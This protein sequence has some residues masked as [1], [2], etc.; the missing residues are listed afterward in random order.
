VPLFGTTTK[1]GF[2]LSEKTPASSEE[3]GSAKFTIENSTG[4]NGKGTGANGLDELTGSTTTGQK[5]EVKITAPWSWDAIFSGRTLTDAQVE[6]K[7][8]DTS[9]TQAGVKVNAGD[10]VQFGAEGKTT[11]KQET[12]TSTT[13]TPLVNYLPGAIRSWITGGSSSTTPTQ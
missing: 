3:Q 8:Y 11:N 9:Q 4:V 6:V 13:T 2:E 7:T 12:L 1:L 5:T 10:G